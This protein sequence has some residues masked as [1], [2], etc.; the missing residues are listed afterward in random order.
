VINKPPKRSPKDA[1]YPELIA[2]GPPYPPYATDNQKHGL[3]ILDWFAGRI[4]AGLCANSAVIKAAGPKLPS[5][6]PVRYESSVPSEP[7]SQAGLVDNEVALSIAE[8]AYTI[9]AYLVEVREQVPVTPTPVPVD[10]STEEEFVLD[11]PATGGKT[12]ITGWEAKKL[13]DTVKFGGAPKTKETGS[14]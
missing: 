4:A 2:G 7:E 3:S 14:A 5:L 11:D 12:V 9:A 6:Q 10:P 8:T 1:P 13:K